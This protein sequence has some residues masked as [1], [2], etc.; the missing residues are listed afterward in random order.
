MFKFSPQMP[1]GLN[2]RD[3]ATFANYYAGPNVEIVTELK[4]AAAGEGEDIIYLTGTRGQGCTHLLKA[5]CHHA[6]RAQLTTV[7]LPL[8]NLIQLTPEVLD[9]L[10]SLHVVCFDDVHAIAG[11][12]IWEEAVFHLFNRIRDAGGK[13]IMAAHDAPKRL[14]LSLPDLVSRLSWG[15]VYKLQPLADEEK[16]FVIKF[17]ANQRGINLPDEVAKYILTHCPRHMR[18]LLAALDALDK[19]S[20]AAQRKITIPFVKE[21]LEIA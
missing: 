20:L 17:C 3:E 9:G 1:L 10:E 8:E 18:T 21:V 5:S 7:Y 2:L 15:M 6:H 14:N 4:K 12:A 13:I 11:N 19:A 16:L